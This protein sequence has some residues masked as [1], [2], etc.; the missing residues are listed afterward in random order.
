[1]SD[2]RRG[3]KPGRITVSLDVANARRMPIGALST[4]SRVAHASAKRSL[5]ADREAQAAQSGPTEPPATPPRDP[6][7]ERR[8]DLAK[9]AMFERG[10]QDGLLRGRQEGYE[11]ARA[12]LIAERAADEQRAGGA[13][14]ERMQALLNG[15]EREFSTMESALAD[16][17]LDLA[18]AL[19][20]R[21]VADHIQADRLAV[22]PVVREC[23]ALVGSAPAQMTIH[24]NPADLDTLA[25]AL[26]D[27]PVFARINLVADRQI[28]A[29]GCRLESPESLID[30]S[31]PT[32]WRRT[33][34]AMGIQRASPGDAFPP[35]S[36]EQI[37]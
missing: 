6:A 24:L 13:A 1:M 12:T 21:I 28:D 19:A 30:A 15:F 32:R 31:L 4:E 29:G 9:R 34:A 8:I 7:I 22:L 25:A 20:E 37:A 2:R 17:V 35:P 23:L 14:A 16:R 26:Q 33:L 18:I 27:T 11:Q 10:V 3:S 5:R 36:D